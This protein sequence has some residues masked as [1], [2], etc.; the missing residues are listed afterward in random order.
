MNS[1]D[2]VKS[3]SGKKRSYSFSLL[4]TPVHKL[5]KLGSELGINLYCKRDDLTGFAMGGNKTRKLDYIIRDAIERG[6]DSIVTFGS[7][8][9]NWCR[10]TAAAARSKGLEAHLILA[11]EKPVVPTA[12]LLL[13]L[14]VGANIYYINSQDEND[15]IAA[16]SNRMEELASAGKK[17]YYVAVGGSNPVGCTGYMRAMAEIIEWEESTGIKFSNLFLASG[18][19]GT[20]AGLVAGKLVAGW[21]GDITGISVS[22]SARLQKTM[23]EEIT[24]AT[25]SFHDMAEYNDSVEKSVITDDSYL[26]EGYR[27]NTRECEEAIKLF[28]SYEGIFLDEVYTGKAAAALIG[29]ARKGMFKKGENILFIHTG[30]VVQLFE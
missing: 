24:K 14:I 28:A 15:L 13:D 17:P 10:M 11:G 1:S 21:E 7:V 6:A 29:Y 4:P 19:A 18:S 20:Q 23:V 27:I 22:R 5:D 8:Q 26:G 3:V 16:C 2:L 25:L 9:S 12:N 30:G